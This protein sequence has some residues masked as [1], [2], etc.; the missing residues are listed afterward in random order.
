VSGSLVNGN[1]IMYDRDSDTRFPQVLAAGI[2]G[3]HSGKA[4]QRGA[5]LNG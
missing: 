1:L 2:S 5:K 4:L 3:P